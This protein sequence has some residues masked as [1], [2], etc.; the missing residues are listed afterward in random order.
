MRVI[1]IGFL[2]CCAC[3]NQPKPNEP[4]IAAANRVFVI[5]LM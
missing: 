3:A 4:I 2:A 1:M 5:D